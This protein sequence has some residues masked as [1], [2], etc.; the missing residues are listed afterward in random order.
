[1]LECEAVPARKKH[2][3]EALKQALETS[4]SIAQ[5]LIK[6]GLVPAGGN[7]ATAHTLIKELNIDTSHMTGMGWNKG[8]RLGLRAMNT[9]P[10]EKILVENSTYRGGSCSLKNR[11]VKEGYKNWI[12]E[13]CFRTTWN[14]TKIPLELEHVN[15]DRFDQRLENLQLLCPNCHAQTPSYRGKNA[16]SYRRRAGMVEC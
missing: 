1:M 15:G 3:K 6:V 10:I 7:Y 12:C 14:G 4:P 9:I 8:D 16:G 5:A 13:R 11:L 2:S